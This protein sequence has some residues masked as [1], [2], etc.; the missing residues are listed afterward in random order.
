MHL[1]EIG[2][3]LTTVNGAPCREDGD[4]TLLG[5]I[6]ASLPVD[7]R[8]G[9]LILL[10]HVLGVFDECIVIAAGLS[11]KSIFSTPMDKKLE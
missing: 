2:A 11:N 10:G 4:L 6:V 5:E 9:K 8:L 3:L 1:K 7:V